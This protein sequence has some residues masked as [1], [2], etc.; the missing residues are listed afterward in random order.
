MPEAAP[1]NTPGIIE[2]K[3]RI[4]VYGRSINATLYRPATAS[5]DDPAPGILFL[6]EIF[7]VIDPLIRDARELAG[8]GYAVLVPD[9]Y[10]EMGA[11]RFCIRE[12]FTA[13][14]INNRPG[15]PALK[16]IFH[17]LDYLESLDTVDRE[18]IGAI[19]M[20]LTGGFIL[21]LARR[22]E[23]KAPVVYHH[24]LGLTGAGIPA[25]D[26]RQVVNTVQGHYVPNDLFCPRSK[27]DQLKGLLGEKLDFHFYPEGHH[28]L[29]SR[30]RNTPEGK[31]AWERTK[32]FFREHLA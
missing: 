11:I 30:D 24:S 31:L 10:S 29:R 15:N 25:D 3:H 13:A 23:L 21:H 16:E 9:L 6:Q 5:K 27:Q 19:G 22:P 26:A 7:G 8:M 1:A 28:G 17:V 14:G 32:T 2:E 12:F 18:R 20:C 4:A